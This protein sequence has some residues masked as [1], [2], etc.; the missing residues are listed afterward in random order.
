[1]PTKE[2][3]PVL[4]EMGVEVGTIMN[5]AERAWRNTGDTDYLDVYQDARTAIGDIARANNT[6]DYIDAAKAIESA[7]KV[8]QEWRELQKRKKAAQEQQSGTGPQSQQ[9]RGDC[10]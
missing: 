4:L 9:R 1:M 8:K 10:T 3:K 7:T 2:L 6:E 5:A